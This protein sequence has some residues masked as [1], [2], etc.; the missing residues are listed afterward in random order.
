MATRL[1]PLFATP[2]PALSSRASGVCLIL[3]SKETKRIIGWDCELGISRKYHPSTAGNKTAF[4]YYSE[5]KFGGGMRLS[6]KHSKPS[7]RPTWPTLQ[8]GEI[9]AARGIGVPADHCKSLLHGKSYL[10]H[11]Y[12]LQVNLM[13]GLSAVSLMVGFSA[14]KEQKNNNECCA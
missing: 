6:S 10:E 9:K 4:P 12:E 2:A 3:H 5:R 14:E 13:C 1:S 7:G 8:H 11:E